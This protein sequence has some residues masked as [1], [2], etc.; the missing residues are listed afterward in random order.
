MSKRFDDHP[1]EDVEDLGFGSRIARDSKLRLL[2][3][4]GTFNVSRE[5]IPL[6][7]FASV[8]ELLHKLPWWKFFVMLGSA[9]LGVTT[10]FALAYV[11]CGPWSLQGSYGETFLGRFADAFSFSVHTIT[12]VGYG[13]ISPMGVCA[14]SIVPLEAFLGLAG[15]AVAAALMFSR[16]ARPTVHI[17]FSDRAVVAPYPGGTGFEFRIANGGMSDLV[18]LEVRVVY[19]Q[20]EDESGIRRRRFQ[21]LA[22]EREK[23]AFF[24]LH[25]TVVHPINESSPLFG[26]T[27]QDLIEAGAEFLVLVTAVDETYSQTVHARGDYIAEEIVWDARFTDIFHHSESG[28]LGIDLRRL[29][30]IEELQLAAF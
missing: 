24:Q 9:Y 14:N 26:K 10:L 25:L 11:S 20:I 22:L 12:T 5:G 19:T 18:D 17:L 8:Y 29:D 6:F 28:L 30:E 16:F 2:N 15:F 23:V 1:P 3:P 13:H 7:R 4:D 21:I 27:R